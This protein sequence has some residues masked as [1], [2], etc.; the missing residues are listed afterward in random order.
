MARLIPEIN[1]KINLRDLVGL[2][3]VMVQPA[4]LGCDSIFRSLPDGRKYDGWMAAR[5]DPADRF[6]VSQ[7]NALHIHK[8]DCIGRTI[9]FCKRRECQCKLRLDELALI[10]IKLIYMLL[11]RLHIYHA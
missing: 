8:I 5:S 2:I 7:E 6:I 11:F 3:L 1:P 9:K 4:C 10:L